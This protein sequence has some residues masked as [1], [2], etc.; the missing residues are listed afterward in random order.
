M[1]QEFARGC[2]PEEILQ[3]V[4]KGRM[5]ALQKPQGGIRGIVVGDVVRRLV[6]RS[7]AQQLGPA[8]EVTRRFNSRCRP[9]L[10]ASAWPTSYKQRRIW[11]NVVVRGW[12]R[13]FRPHLA[14]SDVAGVE[15]GGGVL[16]FVRQFEQFP[17]NV[18]V[19]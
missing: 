19:D 10:D 5:I 17:F 3:V 7:L 12:E 18:L 11:T 6:A 15:G 14:R 9:S 8:V 2:L 1:C 16:L 4:R 13:G